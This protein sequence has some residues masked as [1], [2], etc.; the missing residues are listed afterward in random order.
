MRRSVATSIADTEAPATRAP[1]E[2]RTSPASSDCPAWASSRAEWADAKATARTKLDA[3]GSDDTFALP[4]VV[5]K[6]YRGMGW[7][8]KPGG[9]NQAREAG[10]SAQ[11]RRGRVAERPGRMRRPASRVS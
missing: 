11:P 4:R 9:A 5:L 6:T 8:R 10:A 2:S 7:S 1:A 3:I